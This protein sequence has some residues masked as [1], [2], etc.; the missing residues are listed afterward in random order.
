MR[1]IAL[2]ELDAGFMASKSLRLRMRW[3]LAVVLLG[4]LLAPSVGALNNLEDGDGMGDEPK[5]GANAKEGREGRG[6]R[7]KGKRSGGD[8]QR[9]AG[10]GEE[11]LRGVKGLTCVRVCVQLELKGKGQDGGKAGGNSRMKMM[12]DRKKKA[13]ASVEQEAEEAHWRVRGAPPSIPELMARMG[14]HPGWT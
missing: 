1:S 10:K 9:G 3:A 13:A 4:L 6:W 2:R 11:R 12:G 7:E 8:P 5:V 14:L